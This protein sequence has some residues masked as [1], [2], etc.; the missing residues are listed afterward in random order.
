MPSLME[1]IREWLA[2][3]PHDDPEHEAIRRRL[4]AQERSIARLARI[5]AELSVR[6][7]RHRMAAVHPNRRATDG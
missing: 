2:P 7:R 4:T 5:D 1:R 3:A 6:D